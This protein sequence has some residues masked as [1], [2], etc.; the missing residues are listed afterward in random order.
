MNKHNLLTRGRR[1][2]PSI[3]LQL[4]IIENITKQHIYKKWTYGVVALNSTLELL[5]NALRVLFQQLA[6]DVVDPS[7][8]GPSSR[9]LSRHLH[10]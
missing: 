2:C 7:K 4:S 9:S 3:Q 5:V 10:V 1:R 8:S 6:A